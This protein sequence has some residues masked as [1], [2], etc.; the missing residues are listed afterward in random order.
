MSLFPAKALNATDAAV[1]TTK[2][3]STMHEPVIIIIDAL[4]DLLSAL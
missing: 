4:L 2:K 1:S 3:R